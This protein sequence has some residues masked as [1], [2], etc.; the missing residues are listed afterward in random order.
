MPPKKKPTADDEEPPPEGENRPK[1]VDDYKKSCAALNVD[2]NMDVADVRNKQT[3]IL[4][5]QKLNNCVLGFK[6]R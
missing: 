2:C 6:G 3:F 1:L 4:R 5:R